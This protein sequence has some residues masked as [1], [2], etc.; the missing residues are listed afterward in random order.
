MLTTPLMFEADCQ[1]SMTDDADGRD[2]LCNTYL[3]PRLPRADVDCLGPTVPSE[4]E[5]GHPQEGIGSVE[6]CLGSVIAA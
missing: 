5:R 4:S 3:R 6:G 1:A 2:H